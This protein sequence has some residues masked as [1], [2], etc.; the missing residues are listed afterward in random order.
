[1]RRAASKPSPIRS[2]WAFREMQI[3]G[4]V[5]IGPKELGQ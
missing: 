1:M 5:R 3:D 2:A 4:D